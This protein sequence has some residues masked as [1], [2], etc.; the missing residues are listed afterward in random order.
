MPQGQC[1]H[2]RGSTR[3]ASQA[4]LHDLQGGVLGRIERERGAAGERAE[5]EAAPQ[6][7]GAA[8][9][10][11]ATHS[12]QNSRQWKRGTNDKEKETKSASARGQEGAGCWGCGDPARH[13]LRQAA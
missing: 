7:C 2:L 5:Q 1:T 9:T 3:G 8:C 10:A 13:W 12:R 4:G 6:R 11:R